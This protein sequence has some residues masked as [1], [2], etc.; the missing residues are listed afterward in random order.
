MKQPGLT[1]TQAIEDFSVKNP[2]KKFNLKN[3][4]P[5]EL[6]AKFVANSQHNI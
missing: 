4:R 1:T 5:N 6:P 3:F 2:K